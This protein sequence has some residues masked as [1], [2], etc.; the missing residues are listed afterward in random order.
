[1]SDYKL[2]RSILVGVAYR[3]SLCFGLVQVLLL[4]CHVLSCC[5]FLNLAIFP[6]LLYIYRGEY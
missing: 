6:W 1:M 3:I 5:L 2:S 4:F